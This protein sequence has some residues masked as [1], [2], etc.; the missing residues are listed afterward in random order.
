MD[1]FEEVAKLRAARRMW[2]RIATERFGAQDPNSGRLRFFSGNSGHD[3]HGAAAAEQRDPFDDPMPGRGARRRAV[4]P[5]DGLR[6]GVR[7]PVGGGG[8][9]LAA[10]AADHR[11]RVR[12]AADR[13]PAGRLVLR[14]AS[15]RRDRGAGRRTCSGRSTRWAA[16]SPRSSRACPSG[17]S[18]SPPIGSSARSPR[19]RDRASGVNVHA[20][21]NAAP[22]DAARRCSPSTRA[23]VERQVA[24]TAE[25]VAARDRGA[26][27]T[28]IAA[29]DVGRRARRRT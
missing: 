24:R 22:V 7:D 23:I 5:R 10:D 28:A 8:H 29:V 17:G 18:P 13:R 6:R 16:R 19:A 14:G 15:H 1:L 12:R 4:D 21:P 25:R 26:C 3:A 2:Y 20:D 9:A 27:A 11:A